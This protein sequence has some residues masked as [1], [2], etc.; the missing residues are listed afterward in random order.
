MED[1]GLDGIDVDYEYPETPEQAAGFVSLLSELRSA[2]DAHAKRKGETN[3]YQ[4]SA[5]VP[6]GAA[7]YQNLLVSKMN[8]YLTMWNLMAYDYA[9]AWSNV[10]DDQANLYGPTDSGTNTDSTI[11]WYVSNGV[12]ASKIAMGMRV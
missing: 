6:A 4:L 2:L 11:A 9:G 8:P 7:N 3:P 5:A 12:P 10:S 1:N